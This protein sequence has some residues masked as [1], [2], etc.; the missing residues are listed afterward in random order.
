MLC[1]SAFKILLGMSPYRVVCERP[2]HLLVKLEYRAWWTIRTPNLDLNAAGEERRLSLKDQEEFSRE[3]YD[4]TRLSKERARKPHDR[5]INRKVFSLSEKSTYTT[6]GFIF[7]RA[8]LGL[9]RGV[10]ILWFKCSL[11]RQLKSRTPPKIMF[12]ANGHKL[13]R[14]LKMPCEG[15]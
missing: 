14:F 10:L 3:P 8:N 2:C 4:N 13:K 5:Q 1:G 11:M 15:G 12:K 7:P 9:C 6:L